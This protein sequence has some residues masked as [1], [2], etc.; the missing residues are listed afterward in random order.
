ME[1]RARRAQEREL[2]GEAADVEAMAA[3]ATKLHG[4]GASVRACQSE[5]VL[6]SRSTQPRLRSKELGLE[7]RLMPESSITKKGDKKI[8]QKGAIES[9]TRPMPDMRVPLAIGA[10]CLR[11]VTELSLQGASGPPCPLELL[12]ATWRSI[13]AARTHAATHQ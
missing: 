4:E 3:A 2:A 1:D 9:Q 5:T 8:R 11:S 13:A 12:P 10:H 7:R 6:F